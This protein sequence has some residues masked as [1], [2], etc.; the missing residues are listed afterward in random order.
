MTLYEKV[1]NFLKD[2]SKDELRKEVP[3]EKILN[4]FDDIEAHSTGAFFDEENNSIIFNNATKKDLAEIQKNKIMLYRKITKNEDVNDAIDE[5]VNEIVYSEDE[6]VIK[7]QIEE[8]NNK[9]KDAV[10][11][12]GKKIIR[13]LDMNKNAYNV[14]RQS[15]IDGQIIIHCQYDK[16][17]RKGIQKLKMIEPI[18][19]YF[20][21]ETNTYKY[22]NVDDGKFFYDSQIKKEIEYQREEIVRNTYG[23]AEGKINLSYLDY[24]IKPSNRLQTLEDLLIPL[25]FSRSISRR[26]FNVDTG[27]LSNSQSLKAMREMQKKFKYKK[28]YN[29]ETGEVTNQQHI[30][31]MVEDYW[32]ANRSGG[33]GTQVDV[34]DE[35]GNLGEINDILYFQKKLYKSLHVPQ[36]R[37]PNNNVD[38]TF[39]YEST[40]VTKEDMKFF[41]FVQRI[42]KIYIDVFHELLKREL[43]ST[44]VMSIQDY[45]TYK[46]NISI[47]FANESLFLEKLKLANFTSKLDVYGNIQ[48]YAGKLF[49][50]ETILKTIFRWTD[51]EIKE[52]FDKIQKESKMSKYAEFY[53][54]DDY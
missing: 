34:L 43:V 39:D 31:S 15:Y 12:A 44:K 24:A 50:I 9:I 27:E 8:D 26:V 54:K 10:E 41:M 21:D 1:K 2:D 18:Y 6:E 42:R 4:S 11:A 32:F 37:I 35:T 47:K 52:N 16:D 23:L 5:I 51:E 20:D 45:N 30:T 38:R 49:P 17:V 36:N 14:V 13:L 40:Q 33:R 3:D 46:E 29:T 53:K 25:R 22:L 19:F 7:I 48:D 28:F